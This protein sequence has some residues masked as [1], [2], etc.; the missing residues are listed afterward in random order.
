MAEVVAIL[1][2][3]LDIPIDK[4]HIMTHAEAADIDGYGYGSGDPETRWDLLVVDDP[5]TGQ[6]IVLVVM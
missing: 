3:V 2:S 5:G 1:A 4:E 6:K